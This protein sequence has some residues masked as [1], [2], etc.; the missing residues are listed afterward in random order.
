MRN[1]FTASDAHKR[2]AFASAAAALL[3]LLPVAA[4]AQGSRPSTRELDRRLENEKHLRDNER[5]RRGMDADSEARAR[6]KEERQALANEAFM[7]LQ[8]LHNDIMTMILSPDAP[9][10]ERVAEAVAETKKRAVQLRANLVL[11]EPGKGEKKEKGAEAEVGEEL[12]ESL[13]HLCA[14]IK[15]FVINLNNSPTDNKAGEQARR[16]LDRLIGLSDKI[17]AGVAKS[18]N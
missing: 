4:S 9:V 11:P 12:K 7:R 5:L 17:A 18:G 6:T 15:S 2:F 13:T 14:L 10:P 16:D 3:F 8:V 1:R